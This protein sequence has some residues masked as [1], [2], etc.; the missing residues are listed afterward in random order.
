M[1]TTLQEL[2]KEAGYRTAKDFAEAIEV[3]PTTYARYEQSPE[4]IPLKQAWMIADFLG[5]SIDAVVGR[6]PI[7]VDSMRGDV[8]KFYDGLSKSSK[9]IFREFKEYLESREEKIAKKRQDAENRHYQQL[10]DFY[11]KQFFQEAEKDLPFGEFIT[12]GSPEEERSAFE[13]F[14]TKRARL[15]REAEIDEICGSLEYE[16]LNGMIVIAH[17]DEDDE[18]YLLQED[19]IPADEAAAIVRDER[20]AKTQEYEKRDKEV[21]D[22]IMIAYDKLHEFDDSSISY[23]IVGF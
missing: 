17:D 16:L 14:I 4:K 6:K 19:A 15:K 5:C 2:R 13:N 9:S 1:A 18:G 3:P 20:E 23:H 21:I 8:Q 10:V 12:F 7:D 11:E 22:K